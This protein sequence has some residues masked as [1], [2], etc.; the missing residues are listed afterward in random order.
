MSSYTYL[1]WCS[2]AEFIIFSFCCTY[3]LNYSVSSVAY[4]HI[5]LGI[6]TCLL[7]SILCSFSYFCFCCMT[8]GMDTSTV[9]LM[10]LLWG[11]YK[12]WPWHDV[13]GSISQVSCHVYTSSCWWW[14]VVVDVRSVAFDKATSE[15]VKLWCD[16]LCSSQQIASKL[17]FCCSCDHCLKWRNICNY[18]YLHVVCECCVSQFM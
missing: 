11:C 8:K 14:W 9:W 15:T 6:S 4:F 10:G 17:Q 13:L 7:C 18:L 12:L 3:A 5:F 1:Y 16:G 2:F